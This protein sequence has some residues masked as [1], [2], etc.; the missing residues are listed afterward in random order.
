LLDGAHG[1]GIEEYGSVGEHNRFENNT[2]YSNRPADWNLKNKSLQ[3]Q[4]SRAR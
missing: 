2:V 1:Y 4:L 3:Q